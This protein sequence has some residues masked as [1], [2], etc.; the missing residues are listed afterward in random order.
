M[1]TQTGNVTSDDSGLSVIVRHGKMGSVADI[2]GDDKS[3]RRPKVADETH[4]SGKGKRTGRGERP[5][6]SANSIIPSG[7][8]GHLATREAQRCR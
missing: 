5:T 2:R 8:Y 3:Q 7:S 1:L 4:A 6:D